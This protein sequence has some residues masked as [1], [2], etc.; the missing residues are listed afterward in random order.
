MVQARSLL[1]LFQHLP[2]HSPLVNDYKVCSI[3]YSIWP[4]CHNLV[5]GIAFVEDVFLLMLVELWGCRK[6]GTLLVH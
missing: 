4:A 5:Q 6:I 1:H 2:H 3:V